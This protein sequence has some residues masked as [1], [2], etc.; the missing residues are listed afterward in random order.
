M[1]FA[2]IVPALGVLVGDALSA[3]GAIVNCVALH[4]CHGPM[5]GKD[6]VNGTAP[7]APVLPTV[8]KMRFAKP[9]MLWARQAVGL[10]GVPQYNFDMCQDQ[11]RGVV[12]DTSIPSAGGK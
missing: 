8:P 10:C 1:P 4:R 6:G 3:T 5:Q 9:K 2:A 12:V 11:L 7:T